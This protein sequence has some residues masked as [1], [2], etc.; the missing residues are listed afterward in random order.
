MRTAF[1][2]HALTAGQDSPV[3]GIGFENLLQLLTAGVVPTLPTRAL[4][5]S[6]SF[7]GDPAAKRSLESTIALLPE[8]VL[9]P[10]MRC[11][12]LQPVVGCRNVVNSGR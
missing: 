8:R 2:N 10:N 6:G 12:T 9:H 4:Q 1:E 7:L 11:L 3:S 5:Q